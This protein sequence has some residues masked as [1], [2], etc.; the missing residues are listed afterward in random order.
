MVAS[1]LA[2]RTTGYGPL[3]PQI[4][5]TLCDAII[6]FR[7]LDGARLSQLEVAEQ[8][9][10]GLKTVQR[11]FENMERLKFVT[12]DRDLNSALVLYNAAEVTELTAKR[13]TIEGGA[14]W[15]AFN[16]SDFSDWVALAYPVDKFRVREELEYRLKQH[17]LFYG[18]VYSMRTTEVI[19]EAVYDLDKQMAKCFMLL[20]RDAE[21]FRNHMNDATTMLKL[22]LSGDLEAGHAAHVAH[23]EK[24]RDLILSKMAVAKSADAH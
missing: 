12:Y 5:G 8:Y 7:I 22:C 19:S 24:T 3:V 11:V 20:W 9:G 6:D 18:M 15:Y 1:T 17:E 2:P 14:L 16:A 4:S 23:I 13:V 10:A 21:V